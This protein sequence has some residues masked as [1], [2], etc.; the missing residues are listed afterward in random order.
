MRSR[1]KGSDP[2]IP[3]AKIAE[4]WP[5]RESSSRFDWTRRFRLGGE[6]VDSQRLERFERLKRFERPMSLVNEVLAG[7]MREA[8]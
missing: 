3:L 6:N 1:Q 5:R 8:T 4:E 7:E 2:V